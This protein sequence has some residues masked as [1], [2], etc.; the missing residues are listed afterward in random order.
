MRDLGWEAE[1]EVEEEEDIDENEGVIDVARPMHLP[2]DSEESDSSGF[3]GEESDDEDDDDDDDID[4]ID[5]D[6]ALHAREVALEYHRLRSGLGAGAGTGPL[7]GDREPDAYHSWNQSV[8]S[9][10]LVA[11]D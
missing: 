1:E 8:R 2:S 5:I 10:P 7:G 11:A 6:G 3:Y 9:F 4:E